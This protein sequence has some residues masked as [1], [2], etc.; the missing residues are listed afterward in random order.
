MT[1]GMATDDEARTSSMRVPPDALARDTT[2]AAIVST[3]TAIV[4]ADAAMMT[5]LT[6]EL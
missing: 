6:N 1:V 4:A 3:D 5:V 2:H